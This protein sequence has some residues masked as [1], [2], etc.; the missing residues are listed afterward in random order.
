MTVSEVVVNF[1]TALLNLIPAFEKVELPWRRPDAYDEWDSVASALF[2][3][4]V[5]SVLASRLPESLRVAFK[6]A[7][8][9][10][11]L[12]EYATVSTIEVAAPLLPSGA[13]HV[14][15]AL[16]TSVEA[17]DSLEVRRVSPDG[18]P[19]ESDL[20]RVP[21]GTASLRLRVLPAG[22]GREITFIE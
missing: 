9:D 18:Q 3:A 21:F 13:R 15:H 5:S 4:L 7:K 6:L 16:G 20:L 10:L 8:Y 11:L 1:R 19:C 2:E 14:F 22:T 12:P 17:L